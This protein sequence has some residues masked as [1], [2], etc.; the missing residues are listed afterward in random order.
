MVYCPKIV[1]HA[2]S[3]LGLYVY[4]VQYTTLLPLFCQSK[5]P[6]PLIEFEYPSF[7]VDTSPGGLVGDRGLTPS[8]TEGG[9]VCYVEQ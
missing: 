6:A 2:Y 5:S 9:K 8:P 4:V 3:V 1:H 7:V